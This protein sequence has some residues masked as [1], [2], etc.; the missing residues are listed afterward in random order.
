M[1]SFQELESSF[2]ETKL[3]VQQAHLTW[4][5]E[6]DML[7]NILEALFY[8]YNHTHESAS[9]N[10]FCFMCTFYYPSALGLSIFGTCVL[11]VNHTKSLEVAAS[12]YHKVLEENRVLHNQVLDL[13]GERL[14]PSTNQNRINIS[15]LISVITINNNTSS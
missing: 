9:L 6:L 1:I 5:Q 11:S 15:W 8:I 12:S 2:R 3:E 14:V 13:K 10:L 7:G 4:K